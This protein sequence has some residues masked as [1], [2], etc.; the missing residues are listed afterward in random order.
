MLVD[1]DAVNVFALTTVGAKKSFV[2][3][4]AKPT[5][6]LLVVEVANGSTGGGF[7][8]FDALFVE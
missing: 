6:A 5:T 7:V 8:E 4:G 1:V 3:E 2:V